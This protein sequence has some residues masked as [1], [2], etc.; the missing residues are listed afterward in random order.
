MD[1]KTACHSN[2][3]YSNARS[4][5]LADQSS[6]ASMETKRTI[7]NGTQIA[8]FLVITQFGSL[9]VVSRL[10]VELWIQQF[11]AHPQKY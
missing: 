4:D 7:S 3:R 5:C 6:E 2:V 11:G 8:N 10:K 1:Y 9:A